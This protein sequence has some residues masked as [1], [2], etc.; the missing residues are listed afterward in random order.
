MFTSCG[1][2][3]RGAIPWEDATVVE[4]STAIVPI[5]MSRS[6][7]ALRS[8]LD[9]AHSDWK[10]T[11]YLL[12]GTSSRGIDCSAFMQVVYKDY[13]GVTL[14][15]TTREQMQLGNSVRKRN[16]KI[17]DLVFLKQVEIPIM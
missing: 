10:G 11:R 9:D 5:N 3:K 16:I 17:G 12:G 2:V 4:G 15:R 8:K 13:F 7:R 1:V 6:E 14:P